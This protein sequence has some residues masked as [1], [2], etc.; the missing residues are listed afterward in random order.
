MTQP[1]FIVSSGRSGT[2]ALA[3]MLNSYENIDFNHEYMVHHVQPL[4][5]KWSHGLIGYREV[6]D[7]LWITHIAGYR[8]SK[9]DIW[10]DASNK[11]SWLISPLDQLFPKAKFIQIV[12]DGRK[13]VSSFFHKLGNEIYAPDDVIELRNWIMN[14]RYMS[15][16][17]PPEKRYWWNLPPVACKQFTAICWHWHLCHTAITEALEDIPE[18]RKRT[19]KLEHIVS[20]PAIFEEFVRFVGVEY[21]DDKFAMLKRPDNVNVPIDFPLDEGQQETF[22]NICGE[23]MEQFGYKEDDY[24]QM[25]Y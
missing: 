23:T 25:E 8:Y 1:I 9:A 12:R 20:D 4:A 13:V 15:V 3:K 7:T 17:P 14:Q 11:L 2:H 24:Y 18:E 6:F 22:W 21:R 10:G 5:V 19:F 16:G